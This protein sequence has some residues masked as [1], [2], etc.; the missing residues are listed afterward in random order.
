MVG[1]GILPRLTTSKSLRKIVPGERGAGEIVD[2]LARDLK[3]ELPEMSGFSPRNLKYMRAFAE[4]Y[5]GT[6]FVHQLGAQIRWKH[7][8]TSLGPAYRTTNNRHS[9]RVVDA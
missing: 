3:L 6:E 7:N 1:T 5:P 8:C 9:S 2:R 4:N